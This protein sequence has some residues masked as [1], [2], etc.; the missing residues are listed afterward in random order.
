MTCVTGSKRKWA[1]PPRV[2]KESS[3]AAR[4]Y[5]K[6]LDK[7]SPSPIAHHLQQRHH[8]QQLE[9]SDRSW[10][11]AEGSAGALVAGPQM[12]EAPVG[13]ANRVALDHPGPGPGARSHR[14]RRARADP[15]K[16]QKR[17]G[18]GGPHARLAETPHQTG[19]D[20]VGEH[21][22]QYRVPQSSR[23]S[24][25]H[26]SINKAARS[27]KQLRFRVPLILYSYSYD[28]DA[29]LLFLCVLNGR[30]AA[31][32]LCA[33]LGFEITRAAKEK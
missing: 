20:G 5:A 7:R 17:G 16:S 11:R 2:I 19:I 18:T 3:S 28:H 24:V 23:R 32:R 26:S 12:G 6:P 1:E 13:P 22:S 33:S 25:P 29:F 15:L 9:I 4:R 27:I 8:H 30:V 31:L 10:V 21:R 14:H